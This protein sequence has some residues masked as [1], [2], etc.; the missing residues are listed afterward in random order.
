[1]TQLLSFP[2]L[3]MLPLT[4]VVE[5]MR[6]ATNAEGRS[7]ASI[8]TH[9]GDEAWLGILTIGGMLF[10]MVLVEI[11]RH[12][13]AET[14]LTRIFDFLLGRAG[15]S[16][17]TPPRPNEQHGESKRKLPLGLLARG[18]I[19]VAIGL[20]LLVVFHEPTLKLDKLHGR[21]E[22]SESRAFV[23]I[24]RVMD[25]KH[26][27]EVTAVAPAA[28]VR[29]MHEKLQMITQDFDCERAVLTSEGDEVS[30]TL[31]CSRDHTERGHVTLRK[32]G[33]GRIRMKLEV[34]GI[35]MEDDLSDPELVR[36]GSARIEE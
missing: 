13:V 23:T 4:R 7:V 26:P 17:D 21:Y 33:N 31:L 28:N 16:H 32:V 15:K 14:L 5:P 9:L 22:S 6:I 20:V 11:L 29:G 27:I 34:G 3:S 35:V 25:E 12:A 2:T 18:A 8:V 19:A 10:A 36:V 30:A 24:P 1:M